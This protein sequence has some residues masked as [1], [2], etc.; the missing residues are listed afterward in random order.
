MERISMT[1]RP[2]RS[3]R[4]ARS[5]SPLFIYDQVPRYYQLQNILLGKINAGEFAAGSK[6][7]TEAALVKEYG[8]SR[9]TVRQAL[10]ALENEGLIRREPG[11]GTFVNEQD[12]FSGSLKFEGSLDELISLGLSDSVEVLT[13]G[14]ILALQADAEKLGLDEG[15]KIVRCTRLRIRQNQPYCHVTNDLP[16][17]IGQ[18]IRRADW[19][20]S[21]SRALEEKLNIPL[22]EAS[23]IVGASLADSTLARL[24][25]CRIGAPLLSVDR[26][27]YTDHGKPV[28]RVRTH[29]RSDIFNFTM[30]L[31]RSRG[32][33]KSTA[34]NNFKRTAATGT[35]AA[36]V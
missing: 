2:V 26:I 1:G 7:P 10:R 6:I 31:G 3:A 17:E 35:H 19:K 36:K 28:E 20:G 15:A 22:R 33:L 13:I 14:T 12:S 27:V 29:Y 34:R 24:L 21:V 5:R 11:R 32:L 9:I 18:K 4:G 30:H 25:C 23:Q 8:I 16:F